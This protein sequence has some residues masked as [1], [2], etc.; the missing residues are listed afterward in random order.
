MCCSF[1]IL[2][3]H[4]RRYCFQNS[5]SALFL[6]SP[7][8]SKLPVMRN[9]KTSSPKVELFKIQLYNAIFYQIMFGFFSNFVIL[10]NLFV[11]MRSS[12]K[13]TP[14]PASKNP[15]SESGYSSGS[16]RDGF[17]FC[18]RMNDI[19]QD[20]CY[21]INIIFQWELIVSMTVT[22][23]F[24]H[25]IYRFEKLISGSNKWTYFFFKE[26]P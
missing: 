18:K 17:K 25:Q 24:S 14:P 19:L 13:K 20:L 7:Q 16:S 5:G 15:R 22:E 3:G 1:L 4:L 12:C 10:K 11:F 2:I 6:K 21:F 9:R 26:S 23:V 8:K